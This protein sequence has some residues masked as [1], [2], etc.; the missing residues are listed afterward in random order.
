MQSRL[1]FRR[2]AHERRFQRGFSRDDI[3]HVLEEGEIIREYPDDASPFLPRPWM[4]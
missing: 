1:K 2:H 3:Q 4:G